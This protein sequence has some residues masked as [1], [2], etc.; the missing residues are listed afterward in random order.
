MTILN[1]L[2]LQGDEKSRFETLAP[3]AVHIYGPSPRS[4]WPRRT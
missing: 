4:S 1:M 2:P 3:E